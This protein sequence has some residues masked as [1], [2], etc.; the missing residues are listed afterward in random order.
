MVKSI[1]ETFDLTKIYKIKS[2]KK[3]I[4]ALDNVN[5]SVNE[6]EIFGLLGPN[7]AGKTT[8]IQILTT[9]RRPTSGYATINGYNIL[10]NPVKM[11]DGI[12]LMLGS[13]M[14]YYRIT[15]YDNL[16]FFCKVYFMI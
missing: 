10:K 14:I 3:E 8:M 1:I 13:K 16:K 2:A 4:K 5:I 7:G 6:G 12:A 11:K 15:A 9:L